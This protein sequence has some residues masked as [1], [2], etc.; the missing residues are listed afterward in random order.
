MEFVYI[1]IYNLRH[2]GK[3]LYYQYPVD[4]TIHPATVFSDRYE[5]FYKAIDDE[6]MKPL[7]SFRGFG[8][9]SSGQP[10]YDV[11]YDVYVFDEDFVYSSHIQQLYC[12]GIPESPVG[13]E[14]VDT[15]TYLEYPVYV[16]TR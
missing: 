16:S 9:Q 11:E 10:Y 8:K 5:Y 6:N 15:I 12:R 3:L 14:L 1:P 7:G 4:T 13:L 2:N